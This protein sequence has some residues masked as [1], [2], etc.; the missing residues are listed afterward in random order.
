MLGAV[1]T[2]PAEMPAP[3]WIYYFRVGK[4]DDAVEQVKAGGGQVLTGPHE[5]PGGDMIIQGL[6]PQGALFALIGKR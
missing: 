5:I 6:D 4:I 3:L 2:K 1:M